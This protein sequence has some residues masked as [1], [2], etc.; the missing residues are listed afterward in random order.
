MDQS[1]RIKQQLKLRT[2]DVFHRTQCIPHIHENTLQKFGTQ[3]KID[4]CLR[5]NGGHI[6]VDQTR[7]LRAINLDGYIL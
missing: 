6:E 2:E 3:I 7:L 1:I 4:I 5:N